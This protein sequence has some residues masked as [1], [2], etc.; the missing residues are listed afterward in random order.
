MNPWNSLARALTEPSPD[1]RPLLAGSPRRWLRALPY[2]VA[3]AMVATLLPTGIV[4]LAAVYG[5]GGYLATVLAI[6]QSVPLLVAV[7]RPLQAWWV[8]APAVLAGAVL[9]YGSPDEAGPWPWPVT[10]LLSYVFLM[11]GLG[12]R[13]RGRTLIAVWLVTA[14]GTAVAGAGFPGRFDEVS[15]VTVVLSGAVLLLTWSLRG[16]GEAQASLARQKEISEAERARA[17]LLEERARIARELHDVVAHHMSV[18]A[19][20]ADSAPYRI[21]G[22]PAGAAEEFAAIAAAARGS[23]GEMRRLLGVLRS[24]E[25]EADKAPQPGLADLPRLVETVGQAGVR[26][27]LTLAG[28]T[29]ALD[30]PEAVTLSAYR[31]VQEA[32][33]NVVRHAPGSAVAVEVSPTDRALRV[34]VVNGPAPG[35]DSAV[36]PGSAGG[37][38]LVGMRE[39]VRLLAGTLDTGPTPDGGFRVAAVLPLDTALGEAS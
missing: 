24:E 23:L 31:I 30:L 39:R 19:V 32:L 8:A 38:G 7:S 37:H 4:Q 22:L 28:E 25:A 21:T 5:V 14:L 15:I 35:G 10:T 11:V 36:E 3:G 2:A 26:A 9:T 1:Q 34:S 33:A 6:A 13:E 20:Q 16:R 29:A 27:E 17:T 18:I 12:L